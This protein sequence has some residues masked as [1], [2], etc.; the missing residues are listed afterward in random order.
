MGLGI[1]VSL[2]RGDW[3]RITSDRRAGFLPIDRDRGGM[4]AGKDV[5]IGPGR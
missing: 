5:E 4:Q 2:Y 1:E 3:C